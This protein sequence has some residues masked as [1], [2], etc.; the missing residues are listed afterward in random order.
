MD[1]SLLKAKHINTTTALFLIAAPF[2]TVLY[3]SF[4]YNPANADNLILYALQLLAD[5]IGML[6]I[7]SL[8]ITIMMEIFMPSHHHAYKLP[9]KKNDKF[10]PTVDVFITTAGEP[11]S[12]ILDTVDAALA[13]DYPHNTIVLDDAQ[14]KSLERQI[15]LRGAHYL[16]RSKN[17]HAKAGNLNFGLN[18]SSSDFFI[19]FDADQ[20]PKKKF[21][22]TILPLMQDEKIAMVQTPQHYSNRGNLIADGSASSQDIF[23]K[24]VC[25]AKNISNSVFCVGTNVLFRRSAVNEIGGISLI[26]HSEDI[27]TSYKMHEKGWKTLFVNKILAVGLAPTSISS[28]LKQQLRWARGGFEMFFYDNPLLSKKLT[29]DQKLQYF[30]SN[31]FYF[32][33]VTILAYILFPIIYLLFDTKPISAVSEID[34][35]LHYI[36]YV[37]LYYSLS[38]LLIG[39]LNISLLSVSLASF[40]PYVL[41]LWYSVVSKSHSWVA[42]SATASGQDAKMKW[43]WPYVLIIVLTIAGLI[44]GW[45][46]VLNFWTTLFYSLLASYNLYLVYRFIT[47]KQGGSHI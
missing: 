9:T 2:V 28:F 16:S 12:V 30:Y 1:I 20:V 11:V 46:E 47:Y 31:S 15:D 35:I 32:V 23:Y 38:W 29:I 42:T 13:L 10:K 24:Y 3:A 27:W 34:W 8:W 19:I 18:Y 17:T 5:T 25:P 6:V 26:S 14:S 36:P 37:A 22:S 7:A 33:G 21:I 39:K 41:A 4:L 45:Y 40:Y 43:L 44:I